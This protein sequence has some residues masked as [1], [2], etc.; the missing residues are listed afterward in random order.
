MTTIN[1]IEDL[2]RILR[3][4]PTWADA[5]RSLLLTEELRDLP[6]RFDRFVQ[7]QQQF[8]EAQLQFNEEQREANRLANLRL[9]SLEGRVGNLEGKEYERTS[10]TK[11]IA[12]SQIVLGFEEP[13]MALNQDGV[14]DPRL[15]RAVSLAVRDGSITREAFAD[16]YEADLILSANENLHAVF[17]VSMTADDEDIVRAKTRASILGNVTGGE[18]TPVGITARLNELRQAQAV[19]EEVTT[20]VVPY[21]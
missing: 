12:R 10:R 13:Y 17:E 5:L 21:P 15:N 9:N 14:V 3:E 6:A 11:A 7:A 1:T 20:F 19:D 16:L 4:Q 18:V 2:A 8:N